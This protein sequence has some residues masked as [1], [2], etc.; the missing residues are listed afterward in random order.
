M[1]KLISKILIVLVIISVFSSSILIKPK[2]S[3]A[4][5]VCSIQSARFDPSGTKSG[6]WYTDA[7]HPDVTVDI[8]TA[9]CEGQTIEVSITEK[10][11]P[12]GDDDISQL[13]NHPITV[14]TSN[15]MI[16]HM[17]AGE[18]YCEVES[19]PDCYYYLSVF[20]PGSI[21][22]DYNSDNKYHGNLKFNC[23]TACLD[24][25]QFVSEELVAGPAN[26]LGT[27]D[28]K[29]DYYPLAPL[30]EVG[31]EC[32]TNPDSN[33]PNNKNCVHTQPTDSNPC[34][35]GDYLNALIK[36]FI[37][38]CAVLAMIMIVIGGIEYMTSE[39]IS[40][41]EEGKKRITGALFGLI[42]ALSSYALLNTINPAVLQICLNKLPEAKV[43][44]TP[45]T[46]ETTFGHPTSTLSIGAQTLTA[47][48]TSQL[49]TITFMGKS[50]Q[51]NTAVIPSLQAINT[52]WQNSSDQAIRN[53]V[54]N[55][56]GSYNCRSVRGQP[57]YPSAHS[58]GIA[59]DINHVT[60]PFNA[61]VCTTNMPPSFVSLFTSNGW[62]WGGN[63][64]TPKDPMHFSKL[65]GETG[66]NTPCP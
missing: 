55:D 51:V 41:K 4:T 22:N 60:N 30:P 21:M 18:N 17:K 66:H 32:A 43:T 1:K 2:I 39:L 64:L 29:I 23:D 3:L 6:S 61:H 36:V 50:V 47:C 65:A 33:D 62:G 37:G 46:D 16:I 54:I 15:H 14:P 11:F 63:W 27:S 25:W 8:V 7:T 35:F 9:N 40:S 28:P 20:L 53:Y 57:T 56:I 45:E 48:N 10:D 5:G 13:N 12:S 31:V 59:L 58:F 26:T 42:I 24:N 52:Q 34:P 44:M 38:L 49:Q 19:N